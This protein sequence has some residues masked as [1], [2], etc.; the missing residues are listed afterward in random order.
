MTSYLRQ[1]PATT[2]AML[3]VFD[4]AATT[5]AILAFEAALARAHARAGLLSMASADLI[6]DSCA[7]L[8]FNPV[9][10]A[11]Q[12]AHAGTIAIPIVAKLRKALS[13][14]PEA[15]EA[16]HHGATSQD[17]A[18]TVLMMQA[19]QAVRLLLHDIDRVCVAL[20][21][22]AE[23]YASTPTIGRTL[24]RNARPTTVGLRIAQWL[25]GIADARDRLKTEHRSL[26]IQLGGPAGTRGGLKQKG[27]AIAETMAQLLALPSPSAGVPWHGRRNAIAALASALAI[28]IGAVGKMAC[29]VA[30]LG[31]DEIG[32][33]FEPRIFGR[34]GSSAMPGKRNPTGCQV[35][36]SAAQRAPGLA[37]SIFAA[38][39]QELERGLGG[40]QG[41]GPVLIDLFLLASGAVSC[42]ATIAEGI[43][44]DEAAIGRNLAAAG[45]GTDVGEAPRIVAALIAA[46]K[47]AR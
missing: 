2:E 14:Y 12:A 17:V 6:A 13:S 23:R 3:A 33:M 10:F 21:P 11:E 5:G 27:E 28:V 26:G 18:D 19:A 16:V 43:E 47:E 40:W 4:D 37:A 24:L 35:V 20:S 8:T 44:I 45:S 9:D 31:Q 15:A 22:L 29:D 41:E 1:R 30:L 32:E 25:A 39:P 34:G 38:M 36:L 46:S 7:K 42:T